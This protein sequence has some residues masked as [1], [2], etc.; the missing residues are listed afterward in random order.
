MG[1]ELVPRSG[2]DMAAQLQWANQL[3][4]S[5]VIPGAF[6][7][8]PSNLIWAKQYADS[9]NIHPMAAV[10]GI[11]VI[12]GK[13]TAS[14][15][16]VSA[17]IRRAGHRLRIRSTTT[18]ATVQI[19]R[20]DDPDYTFEVTWTLLKNNDDYPSGEQAGL[21]RMVNGKL[22]GKDNWVKYPSA[23]LTWRA[24]TECGRQACE[25]DLFGLHHVPEEINPNVIVNQD[26]HPVDV[27]GSHVRV[28]RMPTV[29]FEDLL[30]PQIAD[31]VSLDTLS[32]LHQ[33]AL[34]AGVV[35]NVPTSETERG[36]T[37]TIL[38]LLNAR[39]KEIK[40][41]GTTPKSEGSG[42]QQDT[43]GE[44]QD[45]TGSSGEGAGG[46]QDQRDQATDVEDAEVV[47]SELVDGRPVVE[48]E[49]GPGEHVLTDD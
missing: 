45:P 46:Q 24:V 25:E 41:A 29:T 16:L 11:Y 17:L 33:D 5:D 28:E 39:V 36:S 15:A 7:K 43:D 30:A 31:A 20:H 1:S 23:M 8:K 44:R 40:N 34:L 42:Q 21:V 9:L 12:D 35:D 48:Y 14:G 47:E 26:G 3:A 38:Q 19:I 27:Q 32:K 4:Q 22:V 2:Q 10:T 49:E 6:R 37:R 18:S 13:P